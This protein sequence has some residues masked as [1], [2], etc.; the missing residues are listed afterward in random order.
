MKQR[1]ACVVV[2]FFSLNLLTVA[3][4]LGTN[5]ALVQVPSLIQ[6]SGVAAD[7]GGNTLSGDREITFSLYSSQQGGE[8]LWSEIQNVR[9][10]RNGDYSV[11]LG[12][13]KPNGV[14]ATLFSAGQAR[15]LAVEIG[16]EGEQPRVLLVSVPYAL[17][18]GDAATIGGLPPSAFVLAAP[19]VESG[20]GASNPVSAGNSTAMAE[21]QSITRASAL[22]GSGTTDFIPLF[23]SSSI[24][25][26]SVLFQSGTGSTAKVGVNTTTPATM[27]DVNGASTVRGQFNLPAQ[28]AATATAGEISHTLNLVASAFSSST[29]KAVNQTFRWQAEPAG[30]DTASPSG[31]LNLLFGSGTSTP[32]ETGL[33]I[34]S[35]GVLK[36]A[37]AQTLPAA[38]VTGSLGDVLP[39]GDVD[40]TGTVSGSSAIFASS[41]LAATINATG[42]ISA[43]G[44][45]SVV[46]NANITGGILAANIGTAGYGSFGSITETG[47]I[48]SYG[49]ISGGAGSFATSSGPAIYAANN[50]TTQ[51]LSFQ[52]NATPANDVFL[53]SQFNNAEKA[54]VWTDALGDFH[55]LGTKS[56]VVPAKD[57]SMRK[58][59][60]VESP[61]VWFDDYGSG[62]LNGGAVTVSLEEGFAE[63]VNTSTEYHV[64]LT[65][66]GDCNGLYVTN[67]TASGFEVRELGGGASSVAFD[68]RIVAIRKGYENVRLPVAPLP[69]L[70]SHSHS[71]SKQRR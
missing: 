7:D 6:F 66:K 30:N 23:T 5:A 33:N 49:N 51:T 56:A 8:P 58:L 17:K 11:Q 44:S 57:G 60:A 36:F 62:R 45:L 14:P 37:P 21:Q 39:I 64:F 67:E 13:T 27:L 28:S 10:G 61:Q 40:A 65:P 53:E 50:A 35:N 20:E 34:A 29:S 59:F 24:L 43:S 68:Y 22:T 4:N 15:W 48:S 26:N 2:A 3:Q 25:G 38:L 69:K 18:A 63:T 47:D 12:I 19:P 71:S 46:G 55:A 1:I 70:A 52:N 31:T 32:A 9:L 54:I 16:G 41:L 42:N